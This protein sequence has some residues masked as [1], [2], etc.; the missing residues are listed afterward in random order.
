[1]STGFFHLYGKERY[2]VKQNSW[3]NADKTACPPLGNEFRAVLNQNYPP[4]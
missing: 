2:K 4:Y 3:S 1:M